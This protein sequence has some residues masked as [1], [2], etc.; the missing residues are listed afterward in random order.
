MYRYY[1]RTIASRYITSLVLMRRF[2]PAP[3][4][5]NQSRLTHARPVPKLYYQNMHI[6]PLSNALAP[7]SDGRIHVM[8]LL[9]H[10]LLSLAEFTAAGRLLRESAKGA[11]AAA[12]A[13]AGAR[14][15]SRAGR[16][17]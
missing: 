6:H 16:Q 11:T 9:L 4:A 1:D 2:V 5:G 14:L 13:G 17:G 10:F 7:C 12:A 3:R 8:I 15:G